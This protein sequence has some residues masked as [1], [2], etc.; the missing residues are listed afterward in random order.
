MIKNEKRLLRDSTSKI[1]A[2]VASGIARYFDVDPNIIRL[3]FIVLAVCGGSGVLIYILL[4]LLLPSDTSKT[5]DGRD[6]FKENVQQM[7]EAVQEFAK[8]V[9]REAH[10]EVS[11]KKEKSQQSLGVILVIVGLIFLLTNLGL[12]DF[13]II[14]KLWPVLLIF[15]GIL[16]V[17]KNEN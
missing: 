8:E 15:L 11:D 9:K 4:W 6:M 13:F 17:Y 14:K 2:G 12:L 16:V 7:K 3:L 5:V 1:L 10:Q